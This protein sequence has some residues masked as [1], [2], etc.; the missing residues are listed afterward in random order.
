MSG[1]FVF[2]DLLQ[3]T[4]SFFN[5]NR[6]LVRDVN[7]FLNCCITDIVGCELHEFDVRAI[8]KIL[9]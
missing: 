4:S 1:G 5:F 6:N 8:E 2:S 9:A 7:D 3:L